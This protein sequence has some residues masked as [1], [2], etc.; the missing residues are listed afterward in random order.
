M[1]EVVVALAI[2]GEKLADSGVVSTLK[3]GR[4]EEGGAD[5]EGTGV[6]IAEGVAI[7]L[8]SPCAKV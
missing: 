7:G 1:E 8:E 2:V 4:D 5:S 3:D 6:G